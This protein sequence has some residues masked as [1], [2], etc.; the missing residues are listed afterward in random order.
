MRR[1]VVAGGAAALAVLALLV[2][3][4]GPRGLA[5]DLAAV[6]PAW[7]ALAGGLSLGAFLAWAEGVRRLHVHV[8]PRVGPIR[9]Q[10]AFLAGVFAKQ[11]VPVGRATG[12]VLVAYA[13]NTQTGGDYERDLA[14]TSVGELSKLAASLVVA[15][16]GAGLLVAGRAPSVPATLGIAVAVGT[17]VVVVATILLVGRR[18][19]LET[20]VL[21]GAAVVRATAGRLSRRV[22]FETTPSVVRRRLS[23]FLASVD[24]LRDQPGAVVAGVGLAHLGWGSFCLALSAS[25]VA[26][27]HDVPLGVAMVVVPVGGFASAFPLPGGV[28]GVEAGMAGL[29]VA[30][31]GVPLVDATATV[32]LFRLASFWLVFLAGG[33][34]SLYLSID[35]RET[36]RPPARGVGPD[37]R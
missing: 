17:V 8:G 13:L 32:L 4:V 15:A 20:G 14:A 35:P 22:A 29:L 36:A 30:V 27:G 33:L 1:R 25:A 5:R 28:G 2:A 11:L 6:R 34:A 37:R 23:A 21:A 9:F 19:L 10:L 16:A 26:L 3:V 18:D 24:V 7:A 31:A 12:P